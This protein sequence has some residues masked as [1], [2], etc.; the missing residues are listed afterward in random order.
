MKKIGIVFMLLAVSVSFAAPKNAAE[1]A[2][3]VS[4]S[5]HG[6]DGESGD[7]KMILINGDVSITRKMNSLGIETK[8]GDKSLLEF[9]LPKD[10]AGTKLLTWSYDEKDDQQWIY[11]PAARLTRR[12]TSKSKSNSFMGS[13][14]TFEDLRKPALEKYNYSNL[15]SVGKNYS[16][17]RVAKEDSTYSKTVVTINMNYLSPEKIEFFDRSGELLKVASYA[18]YKQFKVDGKTFWRPGSI[19]MENKQTS[20]KS[21]IRWTNRELGGKFPENKFSKGALKR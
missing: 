21:I 13:E 12:I 19:E 10:I 15:K 3:L 14:F 4:E 8:E 2:Q 18:G 7:M 20:K 11:M 9:V 6:Y 16:Y 1:L 17:E 5:N